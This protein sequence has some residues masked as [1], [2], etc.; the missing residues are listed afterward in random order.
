[1]VNYSKGALGQ[2]VRELRERQ[3]VTQEELGRVA[4]YGT[5][6]GVSIS[7]LENGLLHPSPER[8]EGTAKALGLTLEE[9]QARAAERTHDHDVAHSARGADGAPGEIREDP[10][11]P[12]LSSKEIK[13]R[14]Q[15]IEL[16]IAERTTVIA[17]LGKQF[18]TQHDRARD[19]FFMKF[20]EIAERI[21][22]APQPDPSQL[23]GDDATDA[24]AVASY[25]L[26]S[27]ATGVG[28]MLAGSAGGAAAGAAVGSAAAYG[29]FV[30]AA[31]FGTAST[32]AAISGLSGV[33]ATNATLALL[34]G[35]TLAAGGAGVAGGTI[36]LASIVAMPMV[37]LTAGGLLFMVR[38]NR[39]QQ[40]K[41]AEQLDEAEAELAATKPGYEALQDILP[42]AADT[43]D[44][45]AT[46]AGH[47]LNR[48]GN[49]LGSALM[50]WD[51]LDQDDQRRYQDFID[52]AAAQ[53]T[54]VTINVQGLLTTRGSDQQDLIELA[55]RVLTQ[56]QDTVRAIV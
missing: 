32:G 9:L 7:R 23:E 35:G 16:E 29:T 3:G 46:H 30:A 47:A 13:A 22:G 36:L 27:N 38:R 41:F 37:L 19:E 21:E 11:A 54:V 51:S 25:R 33:A 18:N 4:G 34:G 31:S 20:V 10:K 17:D 53:L 55:D 44:Y 8:F 15:S 48:W 1:M 42:R 40:Q 6:A 26:K 28:Q 45:I 14:K 24:E 12:L 50:T 2:V 52:I 56:S 39:K 49:Q 5:G 43:L